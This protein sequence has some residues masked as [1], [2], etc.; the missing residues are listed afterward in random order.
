MEIKEILEQVK[1]NKITL[2]Q[3]EKEIK[4]VITNSF[5]IIDAPKSILR[6]FNILSNK[7]VIETISLNR[8]NAKE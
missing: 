7:F 1:E 5:H 6:H 3:A 4:K 8:R 2:E